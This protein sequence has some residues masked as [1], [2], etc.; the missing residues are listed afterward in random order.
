MPREHTKAVISRDRTEAARLSTAS[1]MGNRHIENSA[2]TIALRLLRRGCDSRREIAD[3]WGFSTRTL[4]QTVVRYQTTGSVAKAAA[5]G[6]GVGGRE[7]VEE[8]RGRHAQTRG[9]GTIT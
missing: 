8:Q 4:R 3:L 6:W 7:D 9:L 1:N 2:K 5:V